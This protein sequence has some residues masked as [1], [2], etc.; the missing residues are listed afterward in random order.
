[1]DVHLVLYLFGYI[2]IYMERVD[3]H[4]IRPVDKRTVGSIQFSDKK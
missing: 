3:L 2:Y 4:G 1:M